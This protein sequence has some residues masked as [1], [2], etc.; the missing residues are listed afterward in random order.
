MPLIV[1]LREGRT[2]AAAASTLDAWDW[3][4]QA[5]AMLTERAR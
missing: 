3:P 4:A 2:V 5:S 1:K